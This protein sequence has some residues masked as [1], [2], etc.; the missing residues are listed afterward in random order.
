ML[1]VGIDLSELVGDVVH[2]GHVGGVLAVHYCPLARVQL[3]DLLIVLDD[4]RQRKWKQ[5]KTVLISFKRSICTRHVRAQVAR[6]PASKRSARSSCRASAH[7]LL[8]QD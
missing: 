7:N 1:G 8:E 3:Y 6:E 2:F 4:L 5:V